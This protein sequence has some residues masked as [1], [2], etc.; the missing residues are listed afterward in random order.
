MQTYTLSANINKD[1]IGDL[2]QT[3]P[4]TNNHPPDPRTPEQISLKTRLLQGSSE[5]HGKSK[6]RFYDNE[7]AQ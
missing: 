3:S 5:L 7:I 4:H 1:L 6:K 2:N